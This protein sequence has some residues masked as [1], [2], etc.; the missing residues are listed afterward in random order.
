MKCNTHFRPREPSPGFLRPYNAL[1]LSCTLC[2]SWRGNL[3]DLTTHQKNECPMSIIQ[4][5]HQ[6]CKQK[7]T[8]NKMNTIHSQIC[9]RRVLS[10]PYCKKNFTY[11]DL[12]QHFDDCEEYP[13]KCESRGCTVVLPRKQSLIHRSQECMFSKVLCEWSE[14]GCTHK[15][16]RS[17]MKNHHLDSTAQHLQCV[18][19]V[20]DKIL[21]MLPQDQVKSALNDLESEKDSQ[22]GSSSSASESFAVHSPGIT[23][24]QLLQQLSPHYNELKELNLRHCTNLTHTLIA[25]VVQNC[26]QLKELDLSKC[27]QITDNSIISLSQNCKQL[28]ELYLENCKQLTD[29]SI[30][31]LAQNCTQLQYL[32]LNECFQITDNSITQ[33]AQNCKQLEGLYL[34][35]CKQ[36]TDTSITALAQNCTQIRILDL[37]KCIQISENTIIQLAHKLPR[38]QM[39]RLNDC[40]QVTDATVISLVK[41]CIELRTL[42]LN[43]CQNVSEEL[44]GELKRL[45][46]LNRTHVFA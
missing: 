11:E 33:L 37:A 5:S 3:G 35:N 8:R 45:G 29:T 15:T 23:D 4:C 17:D 13:V 42:H 25:K 31:A 38:L 24:E 40:N 16:T 18:K 12:K 28:E 30:T 19:N 26:T 1:K 22:R 21:T 43:D 27:S 32:D 36:L 9:A 34:E 6:G 2:G 7:Q 41:S 39:L 44:R 14:Y 46:I 10:C 20:L